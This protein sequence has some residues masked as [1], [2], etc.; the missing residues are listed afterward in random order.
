[1]KKALIS[2]SDKSGLVDF[3]KPLVNQFEF[4]STSGS[5]QILNA[6][7]I[8][9]QKIEDYTGVPILLGGKVKTLH[10]KIF[11]GILGSGDDAAIPAIR[12]V[13]ANLYPVETGE[14]DIG[15]SALL[16]AAAKNYEQVVVVCDPADYKEV[17]VRLQEGSLDRKFRKILAA[18]AFQLTASYDAAISDSLQDELFPKQ[19]SLSFT[20]AKRLSYGE[21]PST[22]A[23]LYTRGLERGSAALAVQ[24]QGKPLSYNNILDADSALELVKKFDKPACAIIKHNNPCGVAMQGKASRAFIEAFEADSLCAF[25]GI[26]AFNCCVDSET[27]EGLSKRFFELVIAPDYE[28]SALEI[29]SRKELLRILK[30]EVMTSDLR[31]TAFK[32]VSGGILVQTCEPFPIREDSWRVVT[33]LKPTQEQIQ[34]LLFAAKV[35]LEVKSNSIVIAKDGVAIGIGAGQMSRIDSVFLALR[36]AQA[37]ARGAVMSSDGF[38]P[39]ADSIEMAAEAGIVAIIQPG[40]SKKDAQVIEACNRKGIAMVLTG[41]RLFKH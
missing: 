34:D 29:L 41:R 14:I 19:F 28:E 38:F 40:G 37:K 21:N 9:A 2:V 3:A 30:T 1:M 17:S 35:N 27:A 11:A 24:L 13:V 36:K 6:A 33:E 18:K 8:P 4:L 5:F 7:G 22:Q 26:V 20:L 23:A 31:K 39:F 15:G 32:E 12:L 16:R 10:P 25:G